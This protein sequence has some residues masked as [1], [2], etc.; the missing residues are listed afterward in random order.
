M[1]TNLQ[2]SRAT[3]KLQPSPTELRS[4]SERR[5]KLQTYV[6]GLLPADVR[7]N[8]DVE[9]H[10]QIPTAAVVPTSDDAVTHAENGLPEEAARQLDT[11]TDADFKII[12]TAREIPLENTPFD[13]QATVDRA[14]QFGAALH[15]VLHILKTASGRQAELVDDQVADQHQPYVNRL[16][17]LIEDSAIEYEAREIDD[18]TETAG[19]RLTLTQSIL[20][21]S[22]DTV[23]PD[24]P[25]TLG[26]R[27][28]IDEALLDMLL[29]N[30]GKFRALM[31]PSDDRVQ[32]QNAD[33]RTAFLAISK[34][35]ASF[36]REVRTYRSVGDGV[37]DH[38]KTASIDRAQ[39]VIDFF[40]GTIK[41]RLEDLS[42]TTDSESH[43]QQ[44]Q[45]PQS[46]QDAH[47]SV[48]QQ[49]TDRPTVI[50]PD[51]SDTAETDESDADDQE[52]ADSEDVATDTSAAESG[53]DGD[54]SA[55]IASDQSDQ[56]AA[57][58]DG[59]AQARDTTEGDGSDPS[60]DRSSE[61]EADRG[62]SKSETAQTPADSGTDPTDA[63]PDQDSQSESGSQQASLT[64]FNADAS[65]S[66]AD[67]RD[68]QES[69]DSASTSEAGSESD[70]QSDT[71]DH[72][73]GDA[74][75]DESGS[76]SA[77][78][79]RESSP[80]PDTEA[81]SEA[82]DAGDD[83]HTSDE[84]APNESSAAD[85]ES[86]Q[87]TTPAHDATPSDVDLSHDAD[88]VDR[89]QDRAAPALSR[90]E[91]E[92]SRLDAE[93][94]RDEHAD[95]SNGQGGYGD[96]EEI[97]VLPEP[98]RTTGTVPSWDEIQQEK[99]R[100]ADRLANALRLS[101]PDDTRRGVSTGTLDTTAVH[102]V[103]TGQT[104]IFAR[105]MPGEDKEYVLTLVLD[106]SG[107][108]GGR[109]NSLI[110]TAVRAVGLF[111]AA[112]EELA[113]DVAI[114]DF[115][116]EE[117]RLIKPVATDLE[118][119]HD[120][121]LT[122]ETSGGTPLSDALELAVAHTRS[123]QK[124]PLVVSVTDGAPASNSDCIDVIKSARLPVAGIRIGAEAADDRLAEAF[125][126]HT[127]L[128]SGDNLVDTLDR[129]AASLTGL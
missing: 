73:D 27:R 87:D 99:D 94:D 39:A 95:L 58:S 80:Q 103:G 21:E 4:G 33:V 67:T 106:R 121:L 36:A 11:D 69:A 85:S 2:P 100:V 3:E 91:D 45:S 64:A 28:A 114:I 90:V 43:Q 52:S 92:I 40:Q 110:G 124:E 109:T 70:S 97:S 76:A 59:A 117:A 46:H 62:D 81:T 105:D 49:A 98:P 12:I 82:P 18:F 50:E 44:T 113:M 65:D 61:Q 17:N 93:L 6:E 75:S 120:R 108:M 37:H 126:E 35:L 60:G 89:E 23:N 101:Q 83:D 104:G 22:V 1:S 111:A 31:N 102:K 19:N 55:S 9:L 20:R 77:D 13:D 14:F 88:A 53:R 129:F 47:E 24:D 7:A 71:P 51:T 10:E 66:D 30:R 5:R 115:Y 8:V 125:V 118:Y 41:P 63:S 116:D 128:P 48:T 96:I 16:L 119:V 78:Q 42:D 122:D 15:E 127:C 84:K 72:Q 26:F 34:E 86:A 57:G 29:F 112:A 74:D 68:N 79:A 107:S 56:S 32:F 25:I 123:Q 54:A 38:D